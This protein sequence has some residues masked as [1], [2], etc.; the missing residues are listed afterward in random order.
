MAVPKGS[1]LVSFGERITYTFAHGKE[2]G[3]IHFDRGRGE[4]FFKGHNIRNME[5]EEWQWQMMEQLRKILT[6]DDRGRPF[7]A[8]YGKILDKIVLEKRVKK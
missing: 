3:S 4:I 7:A 5:V 8:P 6:A 1:Q 2:V